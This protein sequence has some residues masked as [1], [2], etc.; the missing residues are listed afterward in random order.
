MGNPF[1]TV[2]PETLPG[3]GIAVFERDDI[4]EVFVRTDCPSEGLLV[5]RDSWYPGWIATVDGKKAPILRVNGCFRGVIVP[6]GEHKVR[7]LYRPVLV[8]ISGAVSLLSLLL[9]I[10]VSIRKKSTPRV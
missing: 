5:L 2:I 1:P 7:F 9:V 4:H 8:Y 6:A 3:K 10:F